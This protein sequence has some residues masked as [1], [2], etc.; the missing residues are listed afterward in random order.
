MNVGRVVGV[1]IAISLAVGLIFVL[2]SI[3]Q[4]MGIENGIYTLTIDPVPFV[5]GIAIAVVG[6]IIA[7][8]IAKKSDDC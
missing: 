2:L 5:V 8:I 4:N 6:P 3:H 7:A 1:I